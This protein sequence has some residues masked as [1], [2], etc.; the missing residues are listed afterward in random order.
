MNNKFLRNIQIGLII[1]PFNW[2]VAF[3]HDNAWRQIRIEIGCLMLTI[4][5]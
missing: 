1:S 2:R 3:D 5:Y 4:G